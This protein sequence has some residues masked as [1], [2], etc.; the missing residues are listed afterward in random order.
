MTD[1]KLAWKKCDP[2]TEFKNV[3]EK[4]G[5]YIISTKLDGEYV[6]KYVGQASNLKE[7]AQQHWS[8]NE[9]NDGLKKHIANGFVMK[10]SYAELASQ[11]DRDGVELF[12]FKHFDPVYNKCT[13]SAKIS[14][15]CSLPEVRKHK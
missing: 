3:S 2:E 13:P 8:K 6:V 15:A 14:I 1:L 9:Q 12:L 11:S 5:V 10:F 7:R 4:A